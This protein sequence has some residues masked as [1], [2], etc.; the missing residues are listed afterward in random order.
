LADR[1]IDRFAS[2][3]RLAAPTVR[4]NRHAGHWLHGARQNRRRKSAALQKYG[5]REL[6]LSLPHEPLT[7]R[8]RLRID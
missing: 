2:G 3:E 8:R 5:L 1:R 7:A 4:T 6:R